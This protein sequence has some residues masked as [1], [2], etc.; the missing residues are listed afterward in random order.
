MVNT[1]TYPLEVV[2]TNQQISS[3]SAKSYEIIYDLFKKDGVAAFYRGF[4]PHLIKGMIRQTLWWPAIAYVPPI[5]KKH[6]ISSLQQC[7]ITGCSIA[8]LD[9]L[10][11]SPLEKWRVLSSIGHHPSLQLGSILKEG[12]SGFLP[13]W[14][15]QSITWSLFLLGQGHFTKQYK[16]G[17]ETK[18]LTG[19][20]VLM[21]SAKLSLIANLIIS[22]FDTLNTI[23]QSGLNQTSKMVN[24]G[25][26][27]KVRQ[28]YRG[29]PLNFLT[30]MI[31]TT[32]TVFL[33]DLIETRK[34]SKQNGVSH[35]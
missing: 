26:V 23:N 27:K 24:E 6:N 20:Q 17:E 32:A 25:L 10:V 29:L 28:L 14:R 21:T 19:Q 15:R 22:P 8:T 13:Y 5:L 2:K 35:E 9:A 33:M 4:L 1:I 34:H 12:W 18:P 31:N 11:N 16:K 7:A 3:S 30:M